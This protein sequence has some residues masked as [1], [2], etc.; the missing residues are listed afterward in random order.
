MVFK[1]VNKNILKALN[2]HEIF[3]ATGIQNKTIP[4]ILEGKD[5]IGVSKTGSGKTAAFV[6]PMLESLTADKHIQ[7]IVICPTRELA[8]QIST[9]VKKF[10]KY[11]HAHVATV[12]GGASM[13][14]QVDEIRR[15]N[16][17]IGT[18]GR[19][20]DHLG[21]RTLNLSK[22]NCLVLDEADKMVDMGFIHDIREII[23][24][25]PKNR[26]IL[27]FGATISDE[28]DNLKERYM[29]HPIIIKDSAH[30]EEDLLEQYYYDVESRDKFSMLVH[31]LNKREMSKV[32]VFCSARYTVEAVTK[33]LRKQDI[34]ADMIHG[35]LSQSRRL[36]VIE[37]FNKNK[38]S[39]LVASS[40]AA[41]G[42]H[43]K[44]VSHVINYDLS[45]DPQE[46][47]HRIGRT[48]RAGEAGKAVT[49]LCPRDHDIFRQIF[50]R[51]P[52][53]V[54]KLPAEEFKRVNFVRV[55]DN[56]GP[57][58]DSFRRSSGGRHSSSGYSTGFSG[59][60][61]SGRSSGGHSGGRSSGRSSGGSSGERRH[62]SGGSSSRKPS[63]GKSGR[64]H[65]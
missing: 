6:V 52:V 41:R 10:G 23:D 43:I 13:G 28:I 61:S 12:Y 49:L 63:F 20:L 36:E 5:V 24:F 53:K 42:L 55:S 18:P 50:S 46:Y 30:V 4:L 39:V 25:A 21:R 17:V 48:A 35:K 44:D 51:Y 8:V 57:R 59:G 32:M 40:V 56:D 58:R 31:L 3:E 16:I 64:R 27:L 29:N 11:V 19:L 34:S 37:Q 1:T 45:Q 38:F 15:A 9:E 22:I 14:V 26:Q 60:R 54:E 2:E 33:N 47:I 65:V 7:K 62:S